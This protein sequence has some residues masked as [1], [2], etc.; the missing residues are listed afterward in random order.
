MTKTRTAIQPK[1][2]YESDGGPIWGTPKNKDIQLQLAEFSAKETYKGLGTGGWRTS[3]ESVD[4]FVRQREHAQL[5]S[6]F[7]WR[8]STKMYVLEAH[9][10][11]KALDFWQM[12]RRAWGNAT[13]EQAM[14]V[15]KTSYRCTLSERQAMALFDKEKPPHRGYK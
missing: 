10:E 11:G 5:T 8:E 15:L 3:D 1:G 13:L 12:K 4:R 7:C 9:L 6:G 14:Q 2:L